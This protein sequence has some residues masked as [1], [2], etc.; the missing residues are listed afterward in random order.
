[1]LSSTKIRCSSV[2][3]LLLFTRWIPHLQIQLRMLLW[4]GIRP[5]NPR[6]TNI[7]LR[8]WRQLWRLIPPYL[9]NSIT[10]TISARLYWCPYALFPFSNFFEDRILDILNSFCC[11]WYFSFQPSR[12]RLSYL[13]RLRS[14]SISF[15]RI[16]AL[17]FHLFVVSLVCPSDLFLVAFF[18]FTA[19][20]YRGFFCLGC[21]AY[22]KY[23]LLFRN[24]LF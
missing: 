12:L 4:L 16:M 11:F 18:C 19:Q 20:K 7:Q 24:T 21:T 13:F 3:S 14:F 22:T 10:R 17:F 5:S 1:M 8:L 6:Y 9:Y 23:I 15:L 2:E